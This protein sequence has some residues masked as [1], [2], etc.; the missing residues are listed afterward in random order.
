LPNFYK[1]QIAIRGQQKLSTFILKTTALSSFY[2]KAPQ[3]WAEDSRGE[4]ERGSD[5]SGLS[6]KSWDLALVSKDDQSLRRSN[7][8]R[9]S[10]GQ[11]CK[12]TSGGLIDSEKSRMYPVLFGITKDS[13]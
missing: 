7:R 5:R 2:S 13:P 8:T 6:R 12:N 4:I 10:N 11:W 3:E 9:L 1:Q